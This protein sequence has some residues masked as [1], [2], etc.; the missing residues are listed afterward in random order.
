MLTREDVIWAYRLCLNREPEHEDTISGWIRNS[1]D[2]ASLTQALLSS[3]EYKAA[4]GAANGDLKSPFW[5][6][7][8]TFDAIGLI[9]RFARRDLQPAPGYVTNFLGVKVQPRFLPSLLSERVNKVEPL[10]L[11]ANWHADIAEWASCLRAVELAG[12][13]FV[14]LELGCGWGC[15]MNNLGVAAKSAGKQVRLYGIEADLEHTE[16][17]KAALSD[18]GI[19]EHEFKLV[20]GIAGKSASLALFPKIKSGINWGGAALFNPNPEQLDSA[21]Q[22]G[23]FVSIPVIDIASVLKDETVVDF[24]HLDIQ[25]AELDLVRE[26][27]GLLCEKVRFVFIGT[28]SKSIEGGLFDL[29]MADGNWKLEM[30]RAA[31]FN[32]IGGMPV[33]S[34]DGVQAWRNSR[35]S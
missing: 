8:T 11:P 5:H 9:K 28:H 26:V 7:H 16:F 15:W 2:R 20:Q 31:L 30:E 33:V 1:G 21:M 17:A 23:N 29:F 24:I 35:L 13:T 6:Y 27:F 10:P 22:S 34:V 19:A 3:P 14:M 18:N 32:I 25:G 4:N 12:D